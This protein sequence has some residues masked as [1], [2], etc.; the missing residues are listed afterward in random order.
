MV[1]HFDHSL[2][3]LFVNSVFGKII[4]ENVENVLLQ[5]HD[6]DSI[7]WFNDNGGGARS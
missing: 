1:N 2:R 5:D 7:L 4:M 3:K 6:Q